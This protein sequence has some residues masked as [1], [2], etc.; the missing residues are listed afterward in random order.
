MPGINNIS[1]AEIQEY[2][3]VTDS[4]SQ[5]KIDKYMKYVKNVTFMQMFGL[6]VSTKIFDGIIEDSLSEDFIG[7]RDFVAM[8]I[9]SRFCEEIYVHTNAGVKAINQPNWSTPK[10]SEKNSDLL[11]LRNAIEKQFVEAKKILCTL[12]EK[13]DNDYQ[14]FSAFEIERV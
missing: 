5:A 1:I 8:C 3:P 2:Y 10:A 12:D 13:P 11:D 4:L 9:A 6:S 14:A 7:F